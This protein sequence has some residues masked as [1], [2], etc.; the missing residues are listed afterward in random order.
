MVFINLG[1]EFYTL[2]I[3]IFKI[4][5]SIFFSLFYS[6]YLKN[7]EF[8]RLQTGKF[9]PRSSSKKSLRRIISTGKTDKTTHKDKIYD[10]TQFTNKTYLTFQMFFSTKKKD[11]NYTT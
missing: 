4:C 6:T 2:K 8:Y 7:K 11:K 5:I 9:I 1:R 10:L 3:N